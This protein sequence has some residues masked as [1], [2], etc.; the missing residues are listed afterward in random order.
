MVTLAGRGWGEVQSTPSSASMMVDVAVVGS[1][2]TDLVRLATLHALVC[3]AIQ[4]AC[5]NHKN[6][7]VLLLSAMSLDCRSLGR[8]SKAAGLVWVLE[9]KEP[10]SA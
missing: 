9:A 4:C 2:M 10:T 1:C 8:L 5:V 6:C 3:V 7:S